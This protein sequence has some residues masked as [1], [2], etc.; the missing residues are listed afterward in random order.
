GRR[1]AHRQPGR[2]VLH[3]PAPHAGARRA[4]ARHDR[5][6]PDLPPDRLRLRVLV[7]EIQLQGRRLPAEVR[8]A[9]A[10]HDA[11][12]RRLRGPH[13]GAAMMRLCRAACWVGGGVLAIWLAPASPAPVR[14]LSVS[15]TGAVV[16]E[17]LLRLSVRFDAPPTG[18]VL[19]RL[20]LVGRDGWLL[21]EPFL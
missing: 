6:G 3:R 15:P 9:A 11:E 1:D 4:A 21:P 13:Q 18:R 20:A 14:V 19:T 2:A 16:P 10:G 5:Q 12:E 7:P 8:Q 17:N